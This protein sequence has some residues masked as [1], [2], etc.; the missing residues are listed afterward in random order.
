MAASGQ[1]TKTGDGEG[2]SELSSQREAVLPGV[3]ADRLSRGFERAGQG[4]FR[5]RV[6]QQ[7][8]VAAAL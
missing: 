8:L 1:S 3:D 7:G 4:L 5:A 2:V 6:L